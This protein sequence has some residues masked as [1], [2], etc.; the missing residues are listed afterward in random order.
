M[1]AKS[2]IVAQDLP[3][4]GSYGLKGMNGLFKNFT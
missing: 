4:K 1:A 2:H 3:N